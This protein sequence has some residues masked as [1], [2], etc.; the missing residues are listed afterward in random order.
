MKDDDLFFAALG[1]S[2]HFAVAVLSTALLPVANF[3]VRRIAG[4]AA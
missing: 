1:V 4:G 3:I 2:I